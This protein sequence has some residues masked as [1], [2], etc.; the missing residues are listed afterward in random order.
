MVTKWNFFKQFFKNLF[1]NHWSDFE[2]I[3][4]ECSSGDPFKYC[5]QNFDPSINMALVNGDFL[6]HMDEEILQK[7][8]FSET[9]AQ[10]LK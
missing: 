7:I 4:Q 3:L 2:T 5:S 10:I 8:F 9:V 1:W 6:H